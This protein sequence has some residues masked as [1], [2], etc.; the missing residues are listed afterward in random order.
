MRQPRCRLSTICIILFII[1]ALIQ[2]YRLFTTRSSD[3]LA[4]FYDHIETYEEFIERHTWNSVGYTVEQREQLYK[5]SKFIRRI[6]SDTTDR[7][8]TVPCISL[9]QK[10]IV[11]S[12]AASRIRYGHSITFV[13]VSP[14]NFDRVLNYN[15]SMRFIELI[16]LQLWCIFQDGSVTP[17]YDHQVVHGDE[18]A[19]IFDCSVPDTPRNELWSQNRKIRV[20][21]ASLHSADHRRH[22]PIFKAWISVPT[23][24]PVPPHETRYQ[25]TLCTS[26]LHNQNSYIAQWIEYHRSIGFRKF[27]IYNT[28]DV[29]DG[30]RQI[31]DV[32]TRKYPNL[33][34]V[35]QWN[36]SSIGLKDPKQRR[37]FQ[38]E[39]V[40]DCF[41]RYGDQSEWLA[42]LDLD[43]YLVLSAS[44]RTVR[45]YLIENFGRETLGSINIWSQ[46]FCT[47]HSNY[48][49]ENEN[50][51]KNLV[52]E[53]FT[54]RSNIVHK[55]GREKYLYRPRFVQYLSIHHQL[56]GLNKIN[57][58]NN[59]LKL[60]HYGSLETI[61][62]FPG[63]EENTHVN[64][65][66][67]RDRFAKMIRSAMKYLFE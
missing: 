10:L 32:Y 66:S 67:I 35:V 54:W 24:G 63:C 17:I 1:F 39:A 2:T 38:V 26:P 4:K 48:T 64:D 16:K 58:P 33:V 12:A 27:V 40:H 56:N 13:T 65:T 41:I 62:L 3:S 61:R 18:R 7:I 6:S 30:L 59:A 11:L 47:E 25:L 44:Y 19:S 29:S 37:Y 31:V 53:R 14:S 43:E 22:R 21:V 9:E 51:K 55:N 8:P 36:F 34:D 49:T 42:M 23:L 20:Y 46:F 28:T 60:A 57:I 52:I 50:N 15:V 5:L 45:D